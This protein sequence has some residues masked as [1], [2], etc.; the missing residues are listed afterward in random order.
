MGALGDLVRRLDDMALRGSRIGVPLG[1]E[2]LQQA[3]TK[4]DQT[5]ADLWDVERV[6]GRDVYG[7]ARTRRRRDV[8]VV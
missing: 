7:M 6:Y 4:D 3:R 1:K 5:V 2:T 8:F